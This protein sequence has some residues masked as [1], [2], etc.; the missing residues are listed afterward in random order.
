MANSVFYSAVLQKQPTPLKARLGT[1]PARD[2]SELTEEQ[3]L[4]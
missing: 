3:E 2:G 1:I 4:P